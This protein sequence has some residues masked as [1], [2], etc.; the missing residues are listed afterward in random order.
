[1]PVAQMSPGGQLRLH[2]SGR[3]V[4]GLRYGRAPVA[5]WIERPVSTRLVA[6]STPA[7][8]ASLDPCADGSRV[9]DCASPGGSRHR[10]R[11]SGF[12]QRLRPGRI[13]RS[14]RHATAANS[15]IEQ[16]RQRPESRGVRSTEP[17]HGIGRQKVEIADADRH[18]RGHWADPRPAVGKHGRDLGQPRNPRF[19]HRG[20]ARPPTVPPPGSTSTATRCPS[21]GTIRRTRGGRGR[22]ASCARVD[23]AAEGGGLALEQR[24]RR[25]RSRGSPIPASE[26]TSPSQAPPMVLALIGR[27]EPGSAR[28][29][30]RRRR[31]AG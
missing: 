22:A 17:F 18:P 27:R 13:C 3:P 2:R 8:G 15:F 6:G 7:G 4:R 24:T 21:A 28:G 9:T 5:Q 29:G 25:L 19:A 26:P 30:A 1:M 20:V 14:E 11:P 16:H 23:R 31:R 10:L 12:R